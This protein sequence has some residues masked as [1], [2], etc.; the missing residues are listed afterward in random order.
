[1]KKS[2]G[3]RG[4]GSLLAAV[5]SALSFG[6]DAQACAFEQGPFLQEIARQA[7][8]CSHPL[9]GQI[10]ATAPARAEAKD[11]SCATHPWMRLRTAASAA[12]S[13]GGALILGETHDN[14]EHH[15]LQSA[16]LA[17]F[18][19]TSS[20]K[21]PAIVFEQLRADQ[22]TGVASFRALSASATSETRTVDD[23]KR[24]VDWD[25]SQWP[26]NVYE[27]LF[28]AA[29][30]LDL[31]IYAGDVARADIRKAAKEGE[32][33]LASEDRSRLGLDVPL[34]EKVDAASEK[35]IEV[36][37]CGALPK[38]AFGG[39][40]FAQRYRDA[41]LAD[42]VIAAGK[43]NGAAFLIAGT[44]HARTDRGVPWYVRKRT[45]EKQVVSVMFIE[46]EDGNDDAQSYIPRGPDGQ[47]AADFVVFTART[48]RG[49]PC[50]KMLK[51]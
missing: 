9:C 16:A 6:S 18:T 26:K 10:L 20:A 46:V 25:K 33:A 22:E 19:D 50:E 7:K 42:A 4:V 27:P 14:A 49:D 30:A 8:T 41:H 29:I 34:G 43:T 51:K 39:M 11:G 15:L 13:S 12:M 23:L 24:L 36:S 37:H 17:E 5:L 38:E 47:P 32:G 3:A 45:P 31:P 35:E 28:S 21:R 48:E 40:A 2:E 1:M 44:G